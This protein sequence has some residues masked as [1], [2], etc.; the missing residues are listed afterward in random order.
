M[1]R[2]RHHEGA[3]GLRRLLSYGLR[4]QVAISLVLVGVIAALGPSLLEIMASDADNQARATIVPLAAAACVWHIALVAH[5]PLEAE[6]RTTA[7]LA[8]MAT[9]LGIGVVGNVLCVPRFGLPGA[10]WSSLAAAA[11]YALGSVAL[12]TA[13]R[14]WK[15]TR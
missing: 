3:V 7:L 8:L 15:E 10:A 13:L 12:S 5:K 14:P 4:L 6:L 11:V 1:M 2:A 9:S